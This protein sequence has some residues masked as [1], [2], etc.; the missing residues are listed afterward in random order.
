[1]IVL[2]ISNLMYREMFILILVRSCRVVDD[3]WE[4]SETGSE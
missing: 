2:D 4:V 3:R 1:M